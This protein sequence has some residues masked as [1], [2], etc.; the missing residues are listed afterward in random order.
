MYVVIIV[1]FRN[2]VP[3]NILHYHSFC[4]ALG[5]SQMLGG[6]MAKERSKEEPGSTVASVVQRKRHRGC[7]ISDLLRVHNVLHSN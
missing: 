7:F 4:L 5:W 2:S 1:E 3:Y 6:M